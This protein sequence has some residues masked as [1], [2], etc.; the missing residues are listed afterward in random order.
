MDSAATVRSLGA[1]H[2]IAVDL[3][4]A[5]RSPD[6]GGRLLRRHLARAL[7]ARMADVPVAEVRLSRT[8]LGAPVVVTPAGWYISQSGR[9]GD[10]LIGASRQPIAVDREPLDDAPPLR[11]MLAPA[12]IQALDRLAPADQ[13]LDWLRRWTIKEAHAK[14]IGSPL[15][16]RPEAIETRLDTAVEATATFEGVSHCWTWTTATAIETVAIWA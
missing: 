4:D 3:A 8:S 1:T 9:G 14:L 12:E 10:W 5:A 2:A 6:A 7:V 16:I 11:D 13:P 15:R